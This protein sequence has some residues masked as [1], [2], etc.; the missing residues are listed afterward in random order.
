MTQDQSF[1]PADL[2]AAQQMSA[3]EAIEYHYDNDTA[4]FSLWLDP[5][6]SYSS[7]RWH[8][9]MTRAPIAADLDEAQRRKL[10][11]HLDAARVGPGHSLLDIGCGWG[12]ILKAA[13]S[14]RGAASALGLTLS[15]DQHTYIEET[16][17]E[18]A[19]A[20]LQDV[21]SYDSEARFDGAI[22]IGAF[23]HF[24]RPEMDR[25]QKIA[26]YRDFFERLHT[27]LNPGAAFSLQTIVWDAVNFEESK[28]WLPQTVFP[29]S[30]IPFIDEVVEGANP[31]FRLAYLE[32]DPQDYAL[33][34]EAWVAN[35]RTHHDEIV[36][37][38]G[39]EKF[40]WFER[41]LR[42]SRLA[43]TRRKNALARFVLLR[44]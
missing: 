5:T 17:P 33:T 22:S 29:Q 13:I 44:R 25:S 19:S 8:D 30:D 16:A 14:E 40:V 27:L 41:Y 23:E 34:L 32:N 28:K 2:Q 39:E 9:P 37:R 20:I 36:E 24:A 12:A 43:F 26:V 1:A 4:F 11:F 42:N 15:R 6:L 21:F 7:G 10:A 3:S 31:T 35:L 38:W 18:G